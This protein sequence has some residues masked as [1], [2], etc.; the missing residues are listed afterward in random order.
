MS[1]TTIAIAVLVWVVLSFAVG[2]FVGA[3]IRS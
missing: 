2:L 3:C 1:Y